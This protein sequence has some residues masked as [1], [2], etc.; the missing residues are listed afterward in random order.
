VA[1]GSWT[2]VNSA[3]L[4]EAL[5]EIT[6]SDTDYIDSTNN[7][8]STT[9]L[10]LSSISDPGGTKTLRIRTEKNATGGNTRGLNYVLKDSVGTIQ[11]GTVNSA[12]DVGYVTYSITI[13][14][15]INDPTTLRVELTPTGA[16]S[17]AV[18]NRRS[19]E[20]S[21]VELEILTP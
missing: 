12:L 5:D 11:S 6:P 13:T 2:A 17:G 10:N 8:N 14:N 19:V 15:T 16:I 20:V 21:W 18:G 4:H 3:T 1:A 7:S 9:D